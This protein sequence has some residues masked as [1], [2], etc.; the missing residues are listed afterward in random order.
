M[1]K[2]AKPIEMKF[3]RGETQGT[4]TGWIQPA[5]GAGNPGATRN[6]R[7]VE[8]NTARGLKQAPVMLGITAVEHAAPTDA[9]PVIPFDT[10][11]DEM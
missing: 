8:S 11:E 6:L 1:D 3:M 7:G 9:P 5:M 4:D 10:Y 2:A